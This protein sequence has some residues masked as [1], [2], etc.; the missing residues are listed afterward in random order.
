MSFAST[1]RQAGGRLIFAPTG[2]VD[3][4]T[5]DAFTDQI[6]AAAREARDVG[7]LVVDLTGLDF[8][9]SRGLRAL[10]MAQREAG[11]GVPIR[12]A[13]PNAQMREILKISRYDMLF[14]IVDEV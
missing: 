13:N 2:R 14:E 8:M 11:D 9:A 3:A 1:A 10:T 7:A 4:A 5:A 12:L 6:V